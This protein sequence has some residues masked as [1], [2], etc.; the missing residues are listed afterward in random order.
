M[1]ID[2]PQIDWITFTSWK[3]E[4]F[5]NWRDWQKNQA[6]E[7][8]DGKIQMYSGYWVGSA[9]VGQGL[10]N[11]KNH[12]IARVSGELS[13]DIFHDLYS[14][15]VK[16]TRIDVQITKKIPENYSARKF[17]DSLRSGDWGN[18]KRDLQLIENSDGLDTVYIGSRKSERF[19]RMYVKPSSEGNFLRFEVEYKGDWANTIAKA[20]LVDYRVLSS[21][22]FDFINTLPL[23]LEGV[24]QGFLD[25]I[26]DVRSGVV[27]PRRVVPDENTYS[28]L[29]DQV[30]PVIWKYLNDPDRGA[31]LANFLIKMIYQSGAGKTE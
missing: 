13:S 1:K 11:N 5:L 14:S 24:L 22:L 2:Y 12:Y 20:Y 16:A 30:G 6:G 4:D 26:S 15:E 18:N 3:A 21:L 19:A 8:K 31:D 9:F 29:I 25:L 28:W 7:V 23:D 27:I 17:V 10:Q